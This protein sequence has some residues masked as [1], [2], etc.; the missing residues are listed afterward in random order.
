MTSPQACTSTSEHGDVSC[1]PAP[2]ASDVSSFSRGG[3]Y[4]LMD[5]LDKVT[6]P[7]EAKFVDVDFARHVYQSVVRRTLD[8]GVIFPSHRQYQ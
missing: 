4:E 8:A 2:K 3:Q 1:L 6:F 5:W 7:T